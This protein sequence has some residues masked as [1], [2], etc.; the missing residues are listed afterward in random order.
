[1]CN[2][3]IKFVLSRLLSDM[4]SIENPEMLENRNSQIWDVTMINLP[5]RCAGL[6]RTDDLHLVKVKRLWKGKSTKKPRT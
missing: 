1:M 5:V 4:K 2:M 6:C 3:K